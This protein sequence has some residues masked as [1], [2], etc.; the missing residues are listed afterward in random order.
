MGVCAATEMVGASRVDAQF[1]EES[2]VSGSSLY[3]VAPSGGN[4]AKSI[5][6]NA[7]IAAA[8]VPLAQVLI[9][10]KVLQDLHR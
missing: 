7:R 2:S 3:L 4:R 5:T 10:L 9:G 1:S 6:K 8:Y